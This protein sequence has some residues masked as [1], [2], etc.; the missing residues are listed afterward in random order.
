VLE[1]LIEEIHLETGALICHARAW[2]MASVPK[3]EGAPAYDGHGG[4]SETSV[5]L[6]IRPEDVDRGEFIDS[7]PDLDLTRF[8]SVF[9]SPSGPLGQGPVTFPLSMGEMVEAGHH[10]D[11]SFASKERG[12]A[13]LAAKAEALAE[14]LQALKDGRLHWRGIGEK[15]GKERQ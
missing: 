2:E 9:P 6:V 8:G 3:P 13:L 12:E 7:A 10:G 4:S 15:F 11:P 5:M 1:T 14:F